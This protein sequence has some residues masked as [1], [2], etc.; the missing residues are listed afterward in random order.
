MFLFFGLIPSIPDIMYN[1]TLFPGGRHMYTL[2]VQATQNGIMIFVLALLL[3]YLHLSSFI[4]FIFE[5]SINLGGWFNVIPWLYGAIHGTVLKMGEGQLVG[6][7]LAIPP[8]DNEKQ[9]DILVTGL[10]ICVLGDVLAW[11]IVLVALL[12]RCGPKTE[13]TKTKNQ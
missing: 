9:V 6:N 11:V 7:H 3:P 1:R 10:K 2:H 4:S 5:V 12:C 8:P 13:T